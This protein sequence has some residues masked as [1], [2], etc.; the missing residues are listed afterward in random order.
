MCCVVFVWCKCVLLCGVG[1]MTL[2]VFVWCLLCGVYCVVCC[3][4]CVVH[5]VVVYVLCDVIYRPSKS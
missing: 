2:V 5:G 1:C 4:F 3:V